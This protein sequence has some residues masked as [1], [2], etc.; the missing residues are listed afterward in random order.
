MAGGTGAGATVNV[1]SIE[2]GELVATANVTA[3]VAVYVPAASEPVTGCRSIDAGAVGP[4]SVA[5]SHGVLPLPYLTASERPSSVPPPPLVT[6]IA[7][8]GGPDPPT[9]SENAAA[10]ALT[11]MAGGPMTVKAT[12]MASGELPATGEDTSMVAP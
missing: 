1:T 6:S 3:T 11:T 9:T 5:P 10:V 12:S 2:T 4:L 8:D 7:C